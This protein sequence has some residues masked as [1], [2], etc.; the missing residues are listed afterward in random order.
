MIFYFQNGWKSEFNDKNEKSCSWSRNRV[1]CKIDFKVQ[2]TTAMPT[3]WE[4][5]IVILCRMCFLLLT[6]K[7]SL[8]SFFVSR[9]KSVPWFES[10]IS[11]IHGTV[12]QSWVPKSNLNLSPGSPNF[13]FEA[14]SRSPS[15]IYGTDSVGWP[16]P[17]I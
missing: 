1:S 2:C 6:Y 17:L 11:L 9:K 3:A 15:Q 8:C 12:M 14:R 13:E 5:T 7:T 16:G 10:R 4:L